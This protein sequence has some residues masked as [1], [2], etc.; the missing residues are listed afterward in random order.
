MQ[1]CDTQRSILSPGALRS[2][3]LGQL[4]LWDFVPHRSGKVSLKRLTQLPS[5]ALH[6]PPSSNSSGN[7][8][9]PATRF[10][11]HCAIMDD[12][13]YAKSL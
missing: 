11:Q 8:N 1:T 9:C 2:L 4:H 3:P 10:L 5:T 7:V 12:P 6:K 13:Y